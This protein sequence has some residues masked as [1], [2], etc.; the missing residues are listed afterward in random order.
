MTFDLKKYYPEIYHHHVE[1]RI[2]FIFK[3]NTDQPYERDQPGGIPYRSERGTYS[4]LYIRRLM[5]LHNPEFFPAEKFSFR[6]LYDVM[7]DNSYEALLLKQGL[8][9]MKQKEQT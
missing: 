2:E 6:T 3:E 5:D 1:E 7:I 4:P 9:I 8:P